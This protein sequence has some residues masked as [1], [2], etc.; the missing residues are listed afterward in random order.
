MKTD[1]AMYKNLR[2]CEKGITALGNKYGISISTSA[3]CKVILLPVT[4]QNFSS[5]FQKI[6]QEA[7][8]FDVSKAIS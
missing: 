1:L 5:N 6:T 7:C 8:G 4:Y 2:V 3:D